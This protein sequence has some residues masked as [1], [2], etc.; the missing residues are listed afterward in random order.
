[1]ENQISGIAEE[2]LSPQ[3]RTRLVGLC[4]KLTGNQDIAEDLAQETLFLA[5]RHMQG[6]RE[7]DKRA[8]WIAGIARNVSLRWLRQHGRD[9]AHRL[10]LPHNVEDQGATTL[11]DLV[12]DEFDLEIELERRELVNLLDRALALLPDE[13]RSVLVKRYVEESPLAEIAEQLGINAS[14]IAMRLQR[15]KLALRKVLTSDMQQ[16]ILTYDITAT[17]QEWETTSLWCHI[18]GKHRLLGKKQSEIGWLYLKC[19][20]CSPGDEVLSKNEGVSVL[21]GMK[22]FK[23]AYARLGEWC[24]NYYRQGLR[25][26]SV[27]CDTCGRTTWTKLSTPAE[28]R[29]LA[30]LSKDSPKWACHRN[31][32]VVSIVCHHCLSFSCTSLEGL[33]LCLPE[34]RN[35]Q[36]AH[37]RIHQLPYR[38]IEFAGR[39]AI[40]TRFESVNDTAS[41]EVISDYET[42][43]VLKIYGGGQ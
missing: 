29:E 18:C 9:Q 26:G 12:A 10:E 28:I 25:D 41:F 16:E 7:Q 38:T 19:P 39:V 21:K 23:P 22:A 40:V 17:A 30:W 43:E 1:M 6:L 20:A 2:F 36:R 11:E 5:W 35:F 15:G 14:A 42:Y 13:T 8:Q 27:V 33:V 31:E 24:H 34:G 32:R 3:E 37:S 4:G